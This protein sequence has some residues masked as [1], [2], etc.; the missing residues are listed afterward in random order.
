MSALTLALVP[1]V[2]RAQLQEPEAAQDAPRGAEE[3]KPVRDE[4]ASGVHRRPI[5]HEQGENPFRGS[6]FLFDQ[7]MTTQTTQLQPSPQLSYVPLYELWFSF[8][9]R[10]YF[11][12]HW[13][14]R[15]RFDLTKELTNNQSTTYYR[16]D[17]FGDIW[18]ELIYGTKVD[19]WPGTRVGIGPRLIWPT[20]KVSQGNGTYVTAG[21]TAGGVHRFR[22]NGDDAPALNE[23]RVGLTFTYQHPFTNATT[24][25]QYGTFAYARQ[26]VGDDD[27]SILSDQL[28]GLT[29]IDHTLWA[30]LDMGL[31][32][33]PKLSVTFDAVIINS[34]H[35]TPTSQGVQTVTGL[36]NP[37]LVDDRQFV[38]NTWIIGGI[39][40]TL[41][42]ELDLT[43]GYYN[44]ANELAPDGTRRGLVGSNNI[45]WSPEARVFFDV[46]A[47]LDVLYDDAQHHKYSKP[48]ASGPLARARHV[49]DGAGDGG[50]RGEGNPE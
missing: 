46:T 50:P 17:V 45:W 13:S 4:L 44:L 2:A 21:L 38:Q 16:E 32:I 3:D 42:D 8:R 23:F 48:Q 11:D 27:H 37:P 25:T 36:V 5:D 26:D 15:A 6:I 35:Y 43:L 22:I 18:T 34:W 47:N 12:D 28:Q 19:F 29:N 24:P 40:Y 41:F 30:L 49:A 14:V 31:Q 20:S 39:D 9:P 33:T 10:Y 1:A 7:S